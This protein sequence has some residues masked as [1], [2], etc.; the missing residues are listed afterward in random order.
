MDAQQAAPAGGFDGTAFD[1][2]AASEQGH[3][4]ELVNPATGKPFGAT[5][6]IVGEDAE[7]M[8][9][10]Q[11][12][13]FDRV[14]REERLSKKSGRP[15]E[16]SYDDLQEQLVQKAVAH[17]T[18]WSGFFAA[19][20][21]IPFSPSAAEG[22]FRRQRWLRDLVLEEARVLGNFVRR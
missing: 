1:P 11:R 18:G 4:I 16:R 21:E 3:T 10:W 2:I 7:R 12:R 9:E 6:T 17:T 8:Q 14:Q 5:V 22:V 20:Q 15:I 13:F 19:G